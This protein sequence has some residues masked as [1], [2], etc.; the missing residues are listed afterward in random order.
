MRLEESQGGQLIIQLGGLMQVNHQ[1]CT[2]SHPFSC[3]APL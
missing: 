1:C 2:L 3:N